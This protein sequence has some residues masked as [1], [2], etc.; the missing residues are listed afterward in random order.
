VGIQYFL[1]TV[2]PLALEARSK[3]EIAT[4]GMINVT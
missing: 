2:A 3:A 4:A 1:G